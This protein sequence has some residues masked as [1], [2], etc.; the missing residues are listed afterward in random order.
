MGALAL[1]GDYV[2]ASISLS[3]IM[4]STGRFIGGIIAYLC[5][6]KIN[7][8]TFLFIFSFGFTL[9]SFCFFLIST[10]EMTGIFLYLAIQIFISLTA[11]AFQTLSAEIICDEGGL[12]NL[13]KNWG[14]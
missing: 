1:S 3:W 11:G 6:G 7:T 10:I 4:D 13:G 8:F 12:R 2:N 5:L 14:T 9:G